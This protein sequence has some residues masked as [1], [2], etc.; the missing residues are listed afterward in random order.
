MMVQA[1]KHNSCTVSFY[2]KDDPNPP[3]ARLSLALALARSIDS[4]TSGL[5][6]DSGAS[7]SD[8]VGALMLIGR[9]EGKPAFAFMFIAN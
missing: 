9:E 2:E 5:S 8:P 6:Q 4:L 1:S 7:Y 3:C